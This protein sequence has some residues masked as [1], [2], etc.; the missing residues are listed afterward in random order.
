M[1]MFAQAI[2]WWNDQHL[3]LWEGKSNSAVWTISGMKVHLMLL[4]YEIS[5]NKLQVIKHKVGSGGLM[6][7]VDVL[8]GGGWEFN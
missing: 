8:L 3:K 5:V 1:A 6:S 7:S 2:W 4:N